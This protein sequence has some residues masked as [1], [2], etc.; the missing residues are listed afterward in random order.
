MC[1]TYVV[2]DDVIAAADD[3]DVTPSPYNDV[4]RRVGAAGTANSERA[5]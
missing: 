3:D 1:V 5:I 4:S 2:V